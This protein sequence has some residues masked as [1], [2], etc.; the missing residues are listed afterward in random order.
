MQTIYA[1]ANSIAESFPAIRKSVG[2]IH[3]LL[4]RRV[5]DAN[6]TVQLDP[7]DLD[8]TLARLLAAAGAGSTA[9][10]AAL[11][12][13]SNLTASGTLTTLATNVGI[14]TVQ[15]ATL[16]T[17]L[18]ARLTTANAASIKGLA[19]VVTASTPVTTNTVTAGTGK[20]NETLYLT[21]A[22]TLAALTLAFPSDANSQVGQVLRVFSTQIVTALTVSAAGLTI[23][24]AAVT[25][26][27]ANTP[28]SFQKVAASTWIRLN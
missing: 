8:G 14:N 17:A 1:L 5:I 11:V 27:A 18:I 20:V 24:G 12:A 3:A 26:L 2:A 10:L 15:G 23:Q 7:D 21:P 9:A 19:D 13:G 6:N 25:A 16:A 28:V 22:G 4:A